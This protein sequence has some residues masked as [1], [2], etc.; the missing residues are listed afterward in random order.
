MLGILGKVK[1]VTAIVM[2]ITYYLFLLILSDKAQV[3]ASVQ[4]HLP[5]PSLFLNLLPSPQE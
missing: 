5:F 2:F 4:R 1:G 3:T